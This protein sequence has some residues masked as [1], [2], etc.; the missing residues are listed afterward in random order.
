MVD[1]ILHPQK[2][3]V[4]PQCHLAHAV[5]VEVEL[6]LH[7]VRKMLVNSQEALQGLYMAQAHFPSHTWQGACLVVCW[8]R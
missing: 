1:L 3:Q 7:K 5:A 8:H 2:R 4:G 6:V